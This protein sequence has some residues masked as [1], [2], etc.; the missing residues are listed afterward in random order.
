MTGSLLSRLFGHREDYVLATKV[1]F[2]MGI[3]PNDGGLSRKH[4]MSAIDASLSRD[5]TAADFE[6]FALSEEEIS[7]LEEKYLPHPILGH[8]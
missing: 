2:P 7:R 4:I 3:G 8:S 6:H 1:Y 5:R